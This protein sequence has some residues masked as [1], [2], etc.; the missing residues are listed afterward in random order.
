MVPGVCFERLRVEGQQMATPTPR[1]TRL[2]KKTCGYNPRAGREAPEIRREKAVLERRAE[3]KR[4][5]EE[6]LKKKHDL[7]ENNVQ[8][9]KISRVH[10]RQKGAK[11]KNNGVPGAVPDHE[12]DCPKAPTSNAAVVTS[13]TASASSSSLKTVSVYSSSG[14]EESW[15]AWEERM[16]DELF[17][18]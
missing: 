16:E 13:A 6:R 7:A 3:L 10:R 2:T 18:A 4:E 11:E 17:Y 15:E 8:G 12:D 14:E 9:L 1:S 5:R